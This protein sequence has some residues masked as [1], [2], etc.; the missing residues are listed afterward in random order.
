VNL[1]EYKGNSSWVEA[2]LIKIK[3]TLLGDLPARQSECEYCSYRQKAGQVENQETIRP[4]VAL[5]KP[6]AKS[7]KKTTLSAKVGEKP[8]F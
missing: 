7:N 2:E 8:L 3:S 6:P 1:I 4:P 5:K